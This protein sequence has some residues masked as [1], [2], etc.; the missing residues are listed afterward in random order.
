MRSALKRRSPTPELVR[1]YR[2]VESD[3][4]PREI[5]KGLV[6]GLVGGLVGTIVMTAFQNGWSKA[7]EALKRGDGQQQQSSQGEGESE[8]ATMKAAGKLAE[9]FGRPLSHEQKKKF[10]PVVHYAFGIA[11][12]AM[13]GAVTELA[14]I[15]GG[16]VSGVS[17]GAALFV[18]ADELAVPAAGLSGKPSEFPLTSHLYGLASHLVYGVTTEIVRRGLRSAL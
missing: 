9:V 11:Q 7:S 18:V 16:L 5:N 14:G 12:G 13:Y 15:Q 4:R 1:K 6:S 3:E 10:G 17:F 8:D 2:H